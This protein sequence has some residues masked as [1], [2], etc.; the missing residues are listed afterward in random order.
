VIDYVWESDILGGRE[1]F[2]L[3]A[4]IQTKGLS[5][6]AQLPYDHTIELINQDLYVSSTVRLRL[7]QNGITF[8]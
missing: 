5:Q 8:C 3:M 7:G 1:T 6:T 2:T 4:V